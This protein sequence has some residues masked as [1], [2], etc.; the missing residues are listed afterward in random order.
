MQAYFIKRLLLIIPTLLGITIACF[1]IMQMVPGG[2]V[3]QFLQKVKYQSQTDGGAGGSKLQSEMT[4]RELANIRKYYGF[5]K[6]IL[7]RYFIWLGKLVRLDLGDSYT[8]GT[9]VLDLIVSRIPISLTF[10]LI[11][12]F[13]TYVVC[14]PLGVKKALS[15]GGPFDNWSSVLVFFGY[16][17]PGYALGVLLIVLFGGGSFWNIFPIGGLM[18]DNFEQLSLFGKIADYLKHLILP[19][20]CY[21]IGNFA[22]LTLLMKNS[23]MEQLNQDYIRTALAKGLT[24][25]QAV[26]HHGLRN[27]LIPIATNIGMIISIIVTGSFLIEKV[28]TI[29]G[30]GL[31]G[32]QSVVNR[33][34]PVALGIIVIT[35]LLALVGRIISDFCLVL[36]DPRIKF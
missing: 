31:L 21:T 8:Y 18:S 29:D 23:L 15:H 12:L 20:T 36:V 13:F 17:I 30:M 26:F 1:V 25:Q 7:T 10:G 22:A 6:P 19:I 5:D 16:S 24:Y 35:S 9:P 4:E 3:E 33:D 32:Y 28:F 34:Y 27:A 14:I 2:P 11:S